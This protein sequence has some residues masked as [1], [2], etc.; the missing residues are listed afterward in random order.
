MLISESATVVFSDLPNYKW[1]EYNGPRART[2]VSNKKAPRVERGAVFGIKPIRGNKFYLIFPDTYNYAHTI[3]ERDLNYLE[4]R[5]KKKRRMPPIQDKRSG[6]RQ[7]AIRINVP[8]SVD[9]MAQ[10]FK[11]QNKV[12]QESKNGVDFSNYQWRKLKDTRFKYNKTSKKGFDIPKGTKFGLRF[13]KQAR[14]GVVVFDD[15]SFWN[16]PS[17]TYDS[18]VEASTIL[19]RVSWLKGKVTLEEIAQEQQRKVSSAKAKQREQAKALREKQREEKRQAIEKE[20]ERLRKEREEEKRRIREVLEQEPTVPKDYA[21]VDLKNP[22]EYLRDQ[23]EQKTPAARKFNNIDLE[24]D[25]DFD[26][27]VDTIDDVDLDDEDQDAE[28]E[29]DEIVDPEADTK[30]V[31]EMF[32]EELE[33]ARRKGR[34]VQIAK[35]DDEDDDLDLDDLDEEDE[36][37]I[38]EEDEDEEDLTYEEA[39]E[40][41]EQEEAL[42][43]ADYDE[44]DE[45]Y[46]DDLEEETEEESEDEDDQ[47]ESEE[48]SDEQEPEKEEPFEE[49]DVIQ[50]DK[51]ETEKREFVILDIYPLKKNENITVYKVYDIGADDGN[52]QTIRFDTRKKATIEQQAKRLRKLNPKEFTE[53]YNKRDMYDKSNEPIAS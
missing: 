30:A 3:D 10:R 52:Y 46:E 44:D 29:E 41:A 15:G 20:K 8:K 1:Y 36:L 2:L 7:R 26:I 34:S 33:E 31:E 27:D 24:E 51:D 50:F 5:S 49:G 22:E 35:D 47:E 28:V 6:G 45:D 32:D 16:I 25:D 38:D 21:P 11:P 40:E 12:K 9:Y 42:D 43:S 39:N 13:M 4:E 18:L 53:Y 19:P 17:D 14:G 48:D 37:D 23:M